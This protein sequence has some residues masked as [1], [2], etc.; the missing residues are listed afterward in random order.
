MRLMK[1]VTHA[2]SGVLFAWGLIISG[3]TQPSKVIGFL[4]VLGNWDPSLALVMAGAIFVHFFAYR[5]IQG[6]T[7]PVLAGR[8]SVPTSR[9][10]DHK[11]IAGAVL[12]GVGWGLAGFC[13]GPALVSLVALKPSTLYFVGSMVFSM[14]IY[15]VVTRRQGQL[16]L[17][18]KIAAQ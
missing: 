10:I 11:L 7:A 13:P 3:M 4:D 14:W 17:S 8:F 5:A 18:T 12:F 9:T 1:L 15:G 6:R 2:L 16:V